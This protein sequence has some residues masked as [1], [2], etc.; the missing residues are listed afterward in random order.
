MSFSQKAIYAINGFDE[1]YVR[2]AFGEDRDLS[3]R[4]RA[5]GYQHK[6][7]RNLGVVRS[8]GEP[9]IIQQ[10]ARSESVCLQE[11]IGEEGIIWR[12]CVE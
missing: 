6:S 12:S 7:L 3:W 1:D 5:A 10:E 11:R 9:E 2:P 4:F 8:G